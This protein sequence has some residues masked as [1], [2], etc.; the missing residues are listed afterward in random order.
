MRLA[1]SDSA[2]DPDLFELVVEAADLLELLAGQGG[3]VL[4]HL[5]VVHGAVEVAADLAAEVFLGRLELGHDRLV[6][7]EEAPDLGELPV[8]GFDAALGLFLLAIDLLDQGLLDL[9]L[10]GGEDLADPFLDIVEE[11]RRF[12]LG[13]CAGTH[14]DLLQN[15]T[16]A[17]AVWPFP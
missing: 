10:L 17:G 2:L 12:D 16:D 5:L 11:G 14:G 3:G 4:H 1:Y 8:D 15:W 13:F 9:A 6:L 7:F